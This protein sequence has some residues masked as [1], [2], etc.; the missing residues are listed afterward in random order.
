MSMRSASSHAEEGAAPEP[1]SATAADWA[2]K[3]GYTSNTQ[4]Y[5]KVD[6]SNTMQ[7]DTT[8]SEHDRRMKAV[9]NNVEEAFGK[10]NKRFTIIQQ[11]NNSGGN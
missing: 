9:R 4:P 8:K 11:N 1:T 2:F 10:M 3:D 5:K 6:P 7:S